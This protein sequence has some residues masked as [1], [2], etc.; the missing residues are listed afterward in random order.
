A[1]AR[2][3]A[4]GWA[5]RPAAERAALLERAAELL[6]KRRGHLIA[7]AAA[8][9]GKSAAQSDP[10]VSEA[11]D[12]ARYYARRAV[13]L[14]NVSGARF[15]P[16]RLIVVTPPWNFP[17][18]I[19]AGGTLAALAAGAAVIHKPAAS[20]PR[21]SM[22]VLETLW[23]AGV[24]RDVCIGMFPDEGAAGR[25]LISHPDVDRVILTGAFETAAR[26]AS[27]RPGLAV[28]A[29]TSGKNALVIT[30]A[31]DRDLA[32]ADL[33]HS[34]FGHAGQKCSAASLGILVGAV[35]DSPRFRRQLIDAASSLVVDW[36][37]NLSATVGPLTEEPGEKLRRAL[38]RLDPGER[39]LL[40]PR[41]LD[42]SGRLWSPGIKDGV[43]PGSFFHLTECFGPVLGLMR[44]ADLDEALALQNATDFGLTAGL[45]SRDP[46]E[47]R[48][49]VDRV[50]AGNVYVNRGI[51]GAIVRRQPF[52]GWKRSS[53]GLGSKAGGPNYVMLMGR[54]SDAP[55]TAEA[56]A[57]LPAAVDAFLCDADSLLG[58]R[59]SAWLRR[60]AVDDE[61]AWRTEFGTGRDDTKLNSEANIFRYRPSSVLVRVGHDATPTHVARVF[62]AAHRA[63]AT[64]EVSTPWSE[65]GVDAILNLAERHFG[66]RVTHIGDDAD[67]ASR[68][69]STDHHRIRVVGRV[70]DEVRATVAARPDVALLDDA[71]TGSGRVELRYWLAE[72][73]VSITLHRF[74]N[75][76]PAFHALAAELAP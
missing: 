46:R 54:W 31:A 65:P 10:E 29:E 75:P 70:G 17:I 36:P 72:Q 33:V 34:A 7:V 66:T 19:P 41:R 49:W 13:E 37:S 15:T 43:A 69:E 18:A 16:D 30:P 47:V 57:D 39:W 23:E 38:T 24:P 55:H 59:H 12:F 60:A 53:V 42:E 68:I 63:G 4:V 9:A 22:A 67:F 62:V 45:H 73:S 28:N 71:V 50:A 51:T 48:A 40:E 35:Y 25:R 5:D 27:W 21:C 3:A 61:V 26:F 8:E 64:P 32:I 11:I 14:E 56:T 52:G 2:A 74:G 76:D 58:A 6:A 44:A 1:R 20:T